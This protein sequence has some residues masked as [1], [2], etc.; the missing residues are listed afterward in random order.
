MLSADYVRR[1]FFIIEAFFPIQSLILC[2]LSPTSFSWFSPRRPSQW[3]R[4]VP[5][6]STSSNVRAPLSG[7][8]GCGRKQWSGRCRGRCNSDCRGTGRR[9]VLPEPIRPQRT[10]HKKRNITCAFQDLHWMLLKV[11]CHGRSKECSSLGVKTIPYSYWIL[12]VLAEWTMTW[13]I[14][15]W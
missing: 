3:L 4:T 2:H 13:D 5:C 9:F 6:W 15:C 8:Q 11:T 14:M 12:H 1:A 10:N 7:P